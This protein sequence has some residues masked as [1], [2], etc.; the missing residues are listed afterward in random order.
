MDSVYQR[1]GILLTK[2]CAVLKLEADEKRF[3]GKD[4]DEVWLGG[5]ASDGKE[6]AFRGDPEDEDEDEDT[7]ED[8]D[9]DED[10]PDSS[11]PFAGG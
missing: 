7:D 8:R 2:N 3:E 6:P 11:W 5:L 10:E 9:D 4:A 1:T